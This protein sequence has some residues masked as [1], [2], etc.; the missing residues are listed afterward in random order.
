VRTHHVRMD[1]SAR[2]RRREC[3]I[4]GNFRKEATVRP[5]HGRPRGHRPTVRPSVR[6]LPRDNPTRMAS[7]HRCL[8]S[9]PP[10]PTRRQNEMNFCFLLSYALSIFLGTSTK[11]SLTSSLL[12]EWHGFVRWSV[13][14]Y[15]WQALAKILDL[16]GTDGLPK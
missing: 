16:K 10:P 13:K 8:S 5:S 4:P 2:P 15:F 9:I 1:V 14:A 11:I 12:K 3:F 6:K 7:P